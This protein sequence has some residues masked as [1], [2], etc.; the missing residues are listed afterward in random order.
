MNREVTGDDILAIKKAILQAKEEATSQMK[1]GPDLPLIDKIQWPVNCTV[2]PGLEGAIACETEVGYV[3]GARGQLVYRG[4]EISISV[5]TPLSKKSASCFCTDTFLM[6]KNMMLSGKN[7]I[8][9]CL[10]QIL[11]DSWKVF[12]WKD[13]APCQLCAWESILC[14]RSR[15]SAMIHLHLQKP[16]I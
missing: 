1:N 5:L 11:F 16:I 9:S 10:F 2:G 14:G 12:L 13:G 7:S 15:L 4:Y 8:P 6:P 3:N